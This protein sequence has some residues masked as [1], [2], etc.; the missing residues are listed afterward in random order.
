MGQIDQIDWKDAQGARLTCT[1]K[2]NVLAENLTELQTMAL[3]VLED[4]LVMG[5][6]ETPRFATPWG[7]LYGSWKILMIRTKLMMCALFTAPMAL[8]SALTPVLSV[9]SAQD[10]LDLD[11]DLQIDVEVES[12]MAPVSPA[13][14]WKSSTRVLDLGN[15]DFNLFCADQVILQNQ[16]LDPSAYEETAVLPDAP[17][18]RR[19]PHTGLR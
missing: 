9:A 13:M 7:K 4:A 8:F 18:A 1:E 15:K 12:G 17:Q 14:G 6:D 19:C 16:G 5:V 10:D 3:D 2:L 11:L